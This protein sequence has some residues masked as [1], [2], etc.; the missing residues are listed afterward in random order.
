MDNTKVIPVKLVLDNDRGTGIS[1][2]GQA[3]LPQE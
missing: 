2:A 1:S 3:L